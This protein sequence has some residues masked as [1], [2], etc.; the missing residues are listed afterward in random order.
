MKKINGIGRIEFGG[1]STLWFT[2]GG[3][4]VGVGATRNCINHHFFYPELNLSPSWSGW[5][6]FNI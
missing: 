2:I 1:S 6:A 5:N 4:L 3:G